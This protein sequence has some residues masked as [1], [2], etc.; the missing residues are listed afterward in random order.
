MRILIDC[1][2]GR[3]DCTGCGFRKDTLCNHGGDYNRDVSSEEEPILVHLRGLV[4]ERVM[5]IREYQDGYELIFSN[6]ARLTALDGEYGGSTFE[7][8]MEEN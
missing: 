7:F 1:P 3:D 2:I 4:G 8:I 6:G 5:A